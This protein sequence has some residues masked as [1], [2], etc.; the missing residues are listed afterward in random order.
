M[1]TTNTLFRKSIVPI[2]LATIWISLSEFVRN[3]FIVQIHWI[4]H[5]KSLGLIFPTKTM[6]GIIWGIWS[7]LFAIIIFIISKKFTLWQTTFLSWFIGFVLMWVV[8]GNLGILP[9]G[10]LF[11]AVPL[12]LFEALIASFIIKSLT[13]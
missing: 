4:E 9:L 2:F 5:Y 8:I 11:W 3:Q 12:S 10:I 7:L 6:N 1:N 13:K